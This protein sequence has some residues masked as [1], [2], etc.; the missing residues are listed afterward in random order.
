[1]HFPLS[2]QYGETVL[3]MLNSSAPIMDG[4][5]KVFESPM[6]P[7]MNLLDFMLEEYQLLIDAN[8]NALLA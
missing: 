3:E 2:S 7:D 5:V 4:I 1:M 8:N 6:P